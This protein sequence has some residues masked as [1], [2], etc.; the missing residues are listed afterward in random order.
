MVTVSRAG[1]QNPLWAHS[2]QELFF[3]DAERGLIAAEVEADSVFRVLRSETLF[4]VAQEYFLGEG[5]DSH[6]IGPDDE[7]FLMLRAAGANPL[8]ALSRGSGAVL[9]SDSS[10][11]VRIILVENWFTELR[12]RMGGN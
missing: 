3:V 8:L 5:T 4:T 9:S 12:E 1:G 10:V 6:D 11:E 7:R 2:G